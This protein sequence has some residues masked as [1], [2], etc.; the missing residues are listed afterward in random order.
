M[1]FVTDL[2]L[3]KLNPDFSPP[4]QVQILFSQTKPKP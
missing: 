3:P 4:L 2:V 1:I